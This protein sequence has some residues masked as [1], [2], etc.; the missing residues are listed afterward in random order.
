MGMQASAARLSPLGAHPIGIKIWTNDKDLTFQAAHA[1]FQNWY[2][3]AFHRNF[4]KYYYNHRAG[5]FGTFA[6]MVT[7]MVGFKIVT[8]YYGTLRDVNA[9]TDAAAAY[10][11]GGYRTDPVPK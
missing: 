1:N 9:A 6:P 2:G 10:G 4:G 11:Q 3:H 8:M 5:S 7:F